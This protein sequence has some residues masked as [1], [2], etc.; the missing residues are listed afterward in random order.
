MLDAGGTLMGEK[1]SSVRP[2]FLILFLMAIL[3]LSADF[4]LQYAFKFTADYLDH[5]E[6]LIML[7]LI[8]TFFMGA[9]HISTSPIVKRF[10]FFLTLAISGLGMFVSGRH[11]WLQ[12]HAADLTNMQISTL[13]PQ[14]QQN[15][16]FRDLIHL[17]YTGTQ[18]STQIQWVAFGITLSEWTFLCFSIFFVIA[19][20]AWLVGSGD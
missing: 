12:K 20:M 11:V 4:Y 3:L 18:A 9:F 5:I 2:I 14:L 13:T 19:A 1:K 8:P 10:Y 7:A 17:I 15:L 6:R 16:S